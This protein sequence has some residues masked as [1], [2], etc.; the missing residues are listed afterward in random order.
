MIEGMKKVLSG[1]NEQEKGKKPVK[2]QDLARLYETIVQVSIKYTKSDTCTVYISVVL[3]N[4]EFYTEQ[5]Y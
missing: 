5:F 2:A 1:E 3:K 4:A